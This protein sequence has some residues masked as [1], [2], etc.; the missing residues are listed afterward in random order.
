MAPD[1]DKSAENWLLC[2][3]N[4]KQVHTRCNTKYI[5]DEHIASAAFCD[6]S[7]LLYTGA[8]ADFEFA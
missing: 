5:E 1:P 7:M 3:A 6:L 8:L 2:D 4:T